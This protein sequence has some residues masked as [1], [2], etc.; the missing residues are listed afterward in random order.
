[1][2]MGERE[3]GYVIG[4]VVGEKGRVVDERGEEMVMLKG[5]KKA[6]GIKRLL[7]LKRRGTT[8]Y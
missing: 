2:G 5:E 7:S 8:P 4:E 6:G 1:M 3:K